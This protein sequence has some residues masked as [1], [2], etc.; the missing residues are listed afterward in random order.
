[1]QCSRCLAAFLL[2]M[3]AVGGEEKRDLGVLRQLGHHEDSWSFPAIV[4]STCLP[5]AVS[6]GFL[7]GRIYHSFLGPRFDLCPREFAVPFHHDTVVMRSYL[8]VRPVDQENCRSIV[9]LVAE[10]LA[11]HPSHKRYAKMRSC[12]RSVAKRML[13]DWEYEIAVN[14][15]AS[16]LSLRSRVNTA[17]LCDALQQQITLFD[18]WTED[19][20]QEVETREIDLPDLTS[21][22]RL[23]TTQCNITLWWLCND[24]RPESEALELL[25]RWNSLQLLASKTVDQALRILVHVCNKLVD[26]AYMRW[27]GRPADTAGLKAYSSLILNEGKTAQHMRA[28]LQESDEYKGRCKRFDCTSAGTMVEKAFLDELLREPEQQAVESYSNL[29]ISTGNL[30][31][32]V[33]ILRNSSEYAEL[34]RIKGRAEQVGR[35]VR[36]LDDSDEEWQTLKEVEAVFAEVLGRKPDRRGASSYTREILLGHLTP[37]ELRNALQESDEFNNIASFLSRSLTLTEAVKWSLPTCLSDLPLASLLSKEPQ[38]EV[39]TYSLSFLRSRRDYGAGSSSLDVLEKKMRNE[40]N[41]MK[42]LQNT[43][44]TYTKWLDAVQTMVSLFD[45]F[46]LS[47]PEEIHSCFRKGMVY[48]SAQSKLGSGSGRIVSSM[49]MQID[50]RESLSERNAFMQTVGVHDGNV[51]WPRSSNDLFHEFECHNT[52]KLLA[53]LQN[54]WNSHSPLFHNATCI[55]PRGSWQQ[56]DGETTFPLAMY[57][58]DRPLYFAEVIRSLQAARSVSTIKLLVVSLDSVRQDMI[59]LVLN[60]DFLTVRLLF[61]PVREDLLSMSPVL[62]IKSHWWWLQHMIWNEVEELRSYDGNIALLEEDHV[63]TPD[64]VELMRLLI[65]MQQNACPQCWGVCVRHGCASERERD[66]YKICRTRAVINTGISFNR[67][68]YNLI[69]QSVCY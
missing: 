46:D 32:V 66:L 18:A 56:H 16:E 19:R 37:Q 43:T 11:R 29:L 3:H 23:A 30:S 65:A 9:A 59:E 22:I 36:M 25:T 12:V 17:L 13:E 1:M 41:H 4:T 35:Y 28:I 44:D 8:L 14:M 20:L 64:Y 6:P 58:N 68:I 42:A 31:L 27:L 63:V 34:H 51:F 5:P 7:S 50:E 21:A 57:V 15:F 52:G 33:E 10:R 48:S 55:S 54:R 62:A 47:L 53:Q 39:Y 2:V 49:S 60:I 61:H 45:L 24:T 38:I 40:S 69:T 26:D 67:S